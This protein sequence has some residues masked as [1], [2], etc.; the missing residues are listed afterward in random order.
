NDGMNALY[1]AARNGHA[2]IVLY[3]LKHEENEHK[4]DADVIADLKN[5]YQYF[6]KS[7]INSKAQTLVINTSLCI[8]LKNKYKQFF[9]KGDKQTAIKI[10]KLLYFVKKNIHESIE[11][12][13]TEFKKRQSYPPLAVDNSIQEILVE[14]K[15]Y[16]I[17]D[18]TNALQVKEPDQA[19]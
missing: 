10:K 17:T 8:A 19:K 12:C 9:N 15:K 1:F 13:L 4:T 14:L 7:H 18:Q 3:L 2:S 16:S 11:F 5:K 6:S